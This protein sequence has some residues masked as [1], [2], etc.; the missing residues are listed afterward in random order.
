MQN[1]GKIVSLPSK[2]F[3]R[4]VLLIRVPPH[5]ISISPLLFMVSELRIF[6][7]ALWF[8]SMP[9]KEKSVEDLGL[10]ALSGIQE[11]KCSEEDQVSN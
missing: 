4:P 11:I 2:G 10:A 7:A 9:I 3:L 5:P 8:W 1:T 6:E